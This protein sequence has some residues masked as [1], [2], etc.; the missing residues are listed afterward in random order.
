MDKR[1]V[2]AFSISLAILVVWSFF[3]TPHPPPPTPPAPGAPAVTTGSPAPDGTAAPVPDGTAASAAAAGSV[4]ASGAEGATGANAGAA[5]GMP[6]AAGVAPLLEAPAGTPPTI[7]ATPFAK[8]QIDSEGGTIRSW[9][10]TNY[11]DDKGQPYEL[12]SPASR[13]SGIYPLQLSSGAGKEFEGPSVEAALATAGQKL[14]RPPASLQSEVLDAGKPRFL[15]FSGRPAV[16]RILNAPD[17]LEFLNK[18]RFVVERGPG[19]KP[20]RT[21][22][23]TLT[24][25]DG[26]G[27]EAKKTLEFSKD[28][29][30]VRM[31]AEVTRFHRPVAAKIAW[32]P[33]IGTPHKEEAAHFEA[34]VAAV[35]SSITRIGGPNVHG[36]GPIAG[37]WSWSGA[38][39]QYFA[40][41]FVPTS[42]QSS[43]DLNPV[44]LEIP[45]EKPLPAAKPPAS[46][47]EKIAPPKHLV[48]L[49]PAGQSYDV[50][51]GPKD[52]QLLGS[53]GLNLQNLVNFSYPVPLIGPM[54]GAL[55][56][57]LFLILRA[58]HNLVGNYGVCI[59]LLTTAI[60][61]L[62]YPIT[63]RTMVKMRSVQ[64]QMAKLKPK[65]DA[66]K[67]KYSKAKDLATRN[68]AN[69]EI[70]ELYRKEGVNPMASLGGCLPLLLQMPVLFALNRLLYVSIDLRQAPFI[71]WIH[72]L[73]WRDPYYIAPIVMGATMFLQQ[74]LA[75]TNA[76]DP[77]MKSQQRMMLFMPLFF[78][79]TFLRLPSGLVLYWFVNN[80]LGIAQ[81]VLINR[82]AKALEARTA[83]APGKA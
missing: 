41:V 2:A 78:T 57:L 59:I 12:V 43:L 30:I 49:V 74:K 35:G 58:L 4:G 45:P 28:S 83:E 5:A 70:M 67:K 73:S 27:L 82:Q 61:I 18:A 20:D 23:V 68:K 11:Q 76:T 36:P 32:G 77:Q 50:Y 52:Y 19:S 54:V 25:S 48:V 15:I 56:T 1:T 3:F 47:A 53:L 29:Y 26:K 31:S 63:Q 75:M 79:W 9:T 7:V 34:A 44:F 40:A 21:E 14:G 72:D 24:Y 80:V 64:Q 51:V 33:G 46:D 37:T 22:L 8:I 42:G 62:F 39:E 60:K 17:P 10:L 81:Q 69:E 65:A 6:S 66:I 16:V 38:E 13:L 55:A 71:G